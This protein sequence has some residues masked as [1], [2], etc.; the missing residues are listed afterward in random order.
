ML[1]E[2]FLLYSIADHIEFTCGRETIPT[3]VFL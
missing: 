3:H 1:L 2:Q